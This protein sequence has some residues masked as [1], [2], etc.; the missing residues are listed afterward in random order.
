MT[1]DQEP[2]TVEESLERSRN[3]Q[4]EVAQREEPD[5]SDPASFVTELSATSRFFEAHAV[6]KVR[7]GQKIVPVKIRSIPKE[8]LEQAMLSMR[9]AKMPKIRDRQSGLLVVDEESSAYRQWLLTYGYIKVV[10]GFADMTLRDKQGRLVWQS[11]G[12]MQDLPGAIRALKDLGI[13]S[14]Q[15]DDLTRAVDALSKLESEQDTDDLLKN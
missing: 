14:L 8:A 2:Y 7:I 9:P 4:A 10:L 13:T 1:E 3:G 11:N 5:L 15:V 12:E 6:A